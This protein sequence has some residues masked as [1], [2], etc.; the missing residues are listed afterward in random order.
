[1]VEGWNVVDDRVEGS[2]SSWQ[3]VDSRWLVDSRVVEGS[4]MDGRV[5][6]R[7]LV[8]GGVEGSWSR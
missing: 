3:V 8:D 6:S 4:L 1:M 2:Y 7:V 5:D